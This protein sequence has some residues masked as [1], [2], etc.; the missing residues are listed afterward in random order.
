M[1]RN[2]GLQHNADPDFYDLGLCA[3][4]D[5]VLASREDL[6][7]LFKVPSLRNVALGKLYFH[8]GRLAARRGRLLRDA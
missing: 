3:R 1:P 2:P 7:G 4:A 8:N 5:G 6:Y